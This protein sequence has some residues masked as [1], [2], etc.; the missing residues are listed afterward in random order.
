MHPGPADQVK[1]GIR[2]S[3]GAAPVDQAILLKKRELGKNKYTNRKQV[4]DK[5]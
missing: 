5:K 4:Q 2:E 3:G 1:N